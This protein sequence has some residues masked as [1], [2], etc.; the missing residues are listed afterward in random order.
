V[1]DP[2]PLPVQ[3]GFRLEA[4]TA[5]GHVDQDLDPRHGTVLV[6]G[7]SANRVPCQDLHLSGGRSREPRGIGKQRTRVRDTQEYC[8]EDFSGGETF[9]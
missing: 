2:L 1:S 9:P 8:R 5:V 3:L 4:V 6:Q 7:H